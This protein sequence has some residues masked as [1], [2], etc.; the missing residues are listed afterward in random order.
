MGGLVE[1]LGEGFE[2]VQEAG[3]RCGCECDAGVWGDV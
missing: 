1:E 2:G 3:A